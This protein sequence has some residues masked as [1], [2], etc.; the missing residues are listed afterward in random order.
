MTFAQRLALAAVSPEQG[1]E[2]RAESESW[3]FTCPGC[4]NQRS[5][6]E[7]GGV[8]YGAGAQG[9]SLLLKCRG[10]GKRC[11]MP[12]TRRAPQ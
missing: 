6:W 4:G 9:K 1:A 7:L 5:V 8:R 11:W 3:I 12:L 10:C 2:L